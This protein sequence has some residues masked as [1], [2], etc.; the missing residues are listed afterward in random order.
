MLPT[1]A[2]L[3]ALLVHLVD[4]RDAVLHNVVL[5]GAMKLAPVAVHAVVLIDALPASP[6]DVRDVALVHAV[7]LDVVLVVA[8]LKD[9]RHDVATTCSGGLG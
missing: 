8:Q 9:T 1:G 3:D 4:A 7:L 5:F 2:L 6:V